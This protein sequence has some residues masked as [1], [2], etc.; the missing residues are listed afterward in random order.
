MCQPV[1]TGVPD[2]EAL[3]LSDIVLIFVGSL[4]AM[5]LSW[6]GCGS[7]CQAIKPERPGRTRRRRRADRRSDLGKPSGQMGPLALSGGFPRS[8]DAVMAHGREVVDRWLHSFYL[9]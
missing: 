7:C 1:D 3:I 5:L 2:A 6:V 9:P 8:H 4:R